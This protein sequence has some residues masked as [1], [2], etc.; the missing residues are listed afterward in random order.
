MFLNFTAY[1]IL[2]MLFVKRI[3]L[4]R[5]VIIIKKIISIM[6]C[7]FIPI[8][9][10]VYGE[11]HTKD[12]SGG[13][14]MKTIYLAGGCFWGTEH[15]LKN[16][17]GVLSTEVGYANGGSEGVC[18][19]DVCSGS[20]HAEVV[21]V[22]YDPSIVNLEFI[23][24]L[25][26]MTIDPLSVNR[27]GNDV[28]TQYR[29][30]IY[31]IDEE[32]R[33][34]IENSLDKLELKLNNPTAIEVFPLVDYTK[35]EEH[36][37]DYLDKNPNG[38]CHINPELFEIAKSAKPFKKYLKPADS[39]LRGLLSPLEYDVTQNAATEPSFRNKY[40][41]LFEKGIY[42]DIVTG[43]PLFVSS[44]KFES[45]CGWPS[46]SKPI[47]EGIIIENKDTSYG[48]VRT[49][50]RSSLGN[51]HLGHV[52]KDGPSELGGLRYCINSAALR[53]IPLAEM[54]SEGYGE[55]ISLIK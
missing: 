26:Y 54:E 50:V 29:T 53:F 8:M 41:N 25:F 1:N 36:H 24:D 51:S 9:G 2:T 5:Q 47:A 55:Y 34:V 7:L 43:E 4:I 14:N 38:Y 17:E 15:F 48:M 37:Q 35:A 19:S 3:M 6:L 31:F 11:V 44:D 45:G 13:V 22:E 16:I 49:E 18:Y 20:G 33:A 21:K 27:Q 40:W 12:N 46:F 39:E 32:D 23:L 30:G 42:V 10:G 52:F 28:G